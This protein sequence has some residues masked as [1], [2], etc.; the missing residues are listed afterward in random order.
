MLEE[1][2]KLMQLKRNLESYHYYK[3]CLEE[4]R[5]KITEIDTRLEGLSS[6]RVKEVFIENKSYKNNIIEL[7]EHKE[8]LEKMMKKYQSKIFALECLVELIPQ[9]RDQYFVKDYYFESLSKQDIAKKYNYHVAG[10]A[11]KLNSVLLQ[12]IKNHLYKDFEI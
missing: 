6:P 2:D 11:R 12:I 3:H 8:R 9:K 1:R 4:T 10:I 7:T 5:L